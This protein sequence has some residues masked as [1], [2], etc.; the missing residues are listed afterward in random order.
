MIFDWFKIINLDDFQDTG[1]PS[2]QVTAV[3]GSK[4]GLQTAI[5]TQ[6]NTVSV[7]FDGIYLSLNLNSKNPFVFENHAIFLDAN[8]DIWCGVLHAN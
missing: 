2:Q 4:L 1:L 8:G 5:V 3:F 7:L 6:G